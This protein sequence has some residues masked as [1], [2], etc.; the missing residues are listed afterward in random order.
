MYGAI[1]SCPHPL[2]Q[3]FSWLGQSLSLEQNSAHSPDPQRLRGHTPG[4]AEGDKINEYVQRGP[5]VTFKKNMAF[6]W[7]GLVSLALWTVHPRQFN[8]RRI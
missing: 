4:L 7:M 8:L 6:D 1:H 2:W 3:H 5:K